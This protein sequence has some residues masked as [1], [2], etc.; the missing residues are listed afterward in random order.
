[1]NRWLLLSGAIALEVT[2]TLS[3]RAAVEH[4]GWIAVVVPCYAAAFAML[5]LALRTGMKVA[6]AYGIWGACGVALVALLG[7][8]IFVS[9]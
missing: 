6:T 5:G 2:A 9:D 3:L 1:M 4:W 7:T 8:L